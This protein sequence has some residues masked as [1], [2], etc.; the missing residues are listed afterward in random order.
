MTKQKMPEAFRRAA[1]QPI[2][3]LKMVLQELCGPAE[4]ISAPDITV[5]S[6]ASQLSTSAR[7][8]STV[9]YKILP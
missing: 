4:F 8:N 2:M 6:P 1:V 7:V 3:S 5:Q 9:D